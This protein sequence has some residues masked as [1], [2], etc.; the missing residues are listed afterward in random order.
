MATRQAISVRRRYGRI[1]I[2]GGLI[3]VLVTIVLT[4]ILETMGTQLYAVLTDVVA[5]MR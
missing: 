3:L 4:L 2:D 1:F 5:A